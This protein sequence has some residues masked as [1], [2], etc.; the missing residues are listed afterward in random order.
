MSERDP[1]E[2]ATITPYRDGPLIVRGP[3]RLLDMHGR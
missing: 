3:V 2:P 1:V